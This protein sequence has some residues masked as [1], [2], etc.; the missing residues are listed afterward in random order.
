M[1]FVC[2]YF[3]FSTLM[4][5]ICLLFQGV[6]ISSIGEL[7]SL[8]L[9]GLTISVLQDMSYLIQDAGNDDFLLFALIISQN[10]VH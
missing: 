8:G 9:I 2:T 4:M 7:I 5:G 1:I 6:K 10:V 3:V